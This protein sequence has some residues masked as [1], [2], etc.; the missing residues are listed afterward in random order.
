MY[1]V[2]K[3]CI[4]PSL[5]T[6]LPKILKKVITQLEL[7]L[8]FTCISVE[9]TKERLHEQTLR[10]YLFIFVLTWLQTCFII[11]SLK[12]DNFNCILLVQRKIH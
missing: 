5:V 11:L 4:V 2:H 10:A 6:L 12:N 7:G 8:A 9:N 1:I 3:S